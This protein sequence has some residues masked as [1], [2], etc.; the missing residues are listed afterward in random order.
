MTRSS[1]SLVLVGSQEPSIMAGNSANATVGG[2][3]GFA[4]CKWRSWAANV[5][6][7]GRGVPGRTVRLREGC[8]CYGKEWNADE[9]DVAD[10]H[11]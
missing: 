11:G 8:G 3:F 9:A 1:G 6:C 2:H 5:E 4:S 10:R 7:T